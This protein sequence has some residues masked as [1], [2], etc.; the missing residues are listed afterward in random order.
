MN[1][2]QVIF[3]QLIDSGLDTDHIERSTDC[4]FEKNEFYFSYRRD[5]EKSGRMMGIIGIS[6]KITRDNY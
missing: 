1:L 2:Q 6:P 4:T 3:D 5:K